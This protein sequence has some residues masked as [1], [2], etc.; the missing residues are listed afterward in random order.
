MR[1]ISGL[2]GL[3][4]AAAILA[5]CSSGG[6]RQSFDAAGV[7]APPSQCNIVPTSYGA[8]ERLRNFSRGN[9]CG[10]GNPWRTYSIANV[11]FSQPADMNCGMSAPLNDWISQAVQPTAQRVFGERVVSVD[12]LASYSC[13]PRNNVSGAR[14]SEHGLGNA[15]DIGAF[16]LASGRRVDVEQGWFGSSDERWFLKQVRR[17]ACN[18]FMTVLGP[19]SDYEHRNHFHLDL[20]VRRSGQ[21]YCH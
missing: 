9:G 21:H 13:R 16:T 7:I 18:D 15:I 5:A 12:V 3:G 2:I 14:L 19:G 17:D 8:A 4:C 20:E 6:S 11:N 1:A 10:I